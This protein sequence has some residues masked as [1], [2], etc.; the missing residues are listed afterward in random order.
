[1]ENEPLF[2]K[3]DKT[4]LMDRIVNIEKHLFAIK[5]WIIFWSI[6]AILAAIVAVIAASIA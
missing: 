5:A 4:I 3:K 2:T 6:I 1:M